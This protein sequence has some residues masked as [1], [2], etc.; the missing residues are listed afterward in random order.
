MATIWTPSRRWNV[1]LNAFYEMREEPTRS[2][3]FVLALQ[4]AVV[5]GIADVAEAV[6]LRGVNVDSS[7][8][9]KGWLVGVYVNYRLTRRIDLFFNT[10]YYDERL[11]GDLIEERSLDRFRARVG[12]I[13]WFPTLQL[14]I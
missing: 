13:Y 6:A 4:P 7:T 1:T 9:V 11:T 5:A 10:S 3:S 14:P 12:V 2:T 8:E